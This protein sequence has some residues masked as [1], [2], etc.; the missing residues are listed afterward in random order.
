MGKDTIYSRAYNKYQNQ[1]AQLIKLEFI[2]HYICTYVC[3]PAADMQAEP[4][5]PS[6]L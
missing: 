2:F 6:K 5:L 3:I 1:T 4:S